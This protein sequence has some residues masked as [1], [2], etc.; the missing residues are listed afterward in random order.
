MKIINLETALKI[1]KKNPNF[2]VRKG[3]NF[4]NIIRYT[5]EKSGKET[6]RKQTFDNNGIL[7]ATERRI[8]DNY[9]IYSEPSSGLFGLQYFTKTKDANE[10][11]GY[12][13][14]SVYA[15]TTPANIGDIRAFYEM[16]A[17]N[18]K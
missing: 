15:E 6:I 4:T 9:S 17:H 12:R 13:L 5:Q 3:D 11:F 14:N 7:K 18:M 1:A 16:Q 10:L 8:N 2:E